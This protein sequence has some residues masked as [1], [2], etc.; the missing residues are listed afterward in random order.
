M[1]VGPWLIISVQI[2]IQ[3]IEGTQFHSQTNYVMQEKY[4]PFLMDVHC[5]KHFINLMV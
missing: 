5:M 1:Y 3:I 4:A 2:F